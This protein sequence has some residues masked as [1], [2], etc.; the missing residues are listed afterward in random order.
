MK[1]EST[2][3]AGQRETICHNERGGKHRT[4]IIFH[5]FFCCSGTF[6]LVVFVLA[7]A[8]PGSKCSLYIVVSCNKLTLTYLLYRIHLLLAFSL[9]FLSANQNLLSINSWYVSVFNPGVP[10]YFIIIHI[11]S[12]ELRKHWLY[13]QWRC[14]WCNGYRRRKWTRRHEFKSWMRLI[15]FHIARISLGKVWIQLFSLQLWVNSRANRVL[16]P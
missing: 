16:Q 4:W 15:A 10:N 14:P 9:E 7:T 11:L 6:F 13:L 2:A 5:V 1:T 12:T 8:C 3:L